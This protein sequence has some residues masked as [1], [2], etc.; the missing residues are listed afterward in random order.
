MGYLRVKNWEQFQ[1][2]KDRD[3]KWIKLHRDVLCDYEI[4]AL[5]E[6][7]QLHLFKIW[8]LASKT[9]NQIP[10]DPSWIA[11]QIGAK[12]KV[13]IKQLVTA[14]FLI[15]YESVQNRTETYLETE[16]EGETETEREAEREG[17]ASRRSAPRTRL[18]ISALPDDWRDYCKTARP[19]L[20]P[21][22]VFLNFSDYHA[23]RGTLMADWKRTWQRWVREEKTRGYSNRTIETPADRHAQALARRGG[24]GDVPPVGPD[25]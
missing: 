12:S 25:A 1:Q 21:D 24:S 10:N 9:D 2:Y 20:N 13:N 11:R 23:G 14:G 19:D 3:P 18:K 17:G 4:D 15:P 5:D 22:S 7:G 8:L 16:T 6:A